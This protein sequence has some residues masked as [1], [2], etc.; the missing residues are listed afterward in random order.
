MDYCLIYILNLNILWAFI[1]SIKH[2]I[3]YRTLE[4]KIYIM[5]AFII[6]SGSFTNFSKIPFKGPLL[7]STT[8]KS[9]F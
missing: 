4:I 6:N 9:S 3:I 1:S 8:K 5:F 2:T 7:Y